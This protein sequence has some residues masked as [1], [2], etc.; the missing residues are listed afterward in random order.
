MKMEIPTDVQLAQD[1]VVRRIVSR[2]SFQL[3]QK[4]IMF[5][6]FVLQVIDHLEHYVCPQYGDWPDEM[7]QGFDV[8]DIRAQL[9]R[10][11]GRVGNNARGP[12]EDHRD[13]L[14][15]AHYACYTKLKLED[16]D[17][18][19]AVVYNTKEASNGDTES[20]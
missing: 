19:D 16:R 18:G 4:S 14:K 10:Y 9:K 20:Q 11:S 3:S 7:I 6:Y 17:G 15:L 5:L 13:A 2:C 12:I 1:E 8:A